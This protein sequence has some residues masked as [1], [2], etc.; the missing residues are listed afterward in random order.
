MNN[1]ALEVLA[2]DQADSFGEFFA[3][4]NF[5]MID[6][7]VAQYRQARERI[8]EVAAFSKGETCNSVISYFLDGNS[9]PDRGRH[10]LMMSAAQLFDESGAT[11]AL[12]AAYW[13]KALELTDVYNAMPQKRRDEWN[14]QLR[15]PK[16]VTKHRGSKGEWETPPLPDFEDETVRATLN[17]LLAARAQFL[18]ERVDGIF[19]ALSGE[20]VTNSPAAFGK[21]MIVAHLVSSYGTSN[22][23]R[24]GYI[25]DLR[26]VIAKFM[27]RDE[28]KWNMTSGI[29]DHA[30]RES[31]GQWV[32]VDGGA[33]RLRAYK[34]GTA[35]LEV[36][37]DMAWRLNS[38]L[39]H[40]YPMAIP[41]EFR[42]KPKKKA[43]EF[44]AMGRPLPFA[45]VELL[46][47]AKTAYRLIPQPDNWRQQYRRE[48]I[49]DTLDISHSGAWESAT[50]PV[51]D[52]AESVFRILGGVK[53]ANGYWQ[54]DYRPNEVLGE[55]VRTGC[56][57]DQKT[58]QFYP[59]PEGLAQIAVGLA[60][61]GDDHQCLEPSAGIGG[62]ADF[63]PI[64]RTTCI[65]VSR[66]HCEVLR[67]KGFTSVEADFP[68]WVDLQF[69][70]AAK[71]DRVVMNPPFSDGRAKA[72]TEFAAQCLKPGG[73]LVAIL[74]ASMKG[75]NF[76]SGFECEWSAIYDNEFAGTSVSV[77]ILTAKKQGGEP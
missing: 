3:P 19:R 8:T 55:A 69:P 41:P 18:A 53:S 51:R 50:K 7:L 56:I 23:D 45:V 1:D 30:R 76:L 40:L 47:E 4:S 64:E 9:D 2:V 46:S 61:I 22:H 14:A 29:V 27:G 67:A 33:L 62:L 13:S 72:H 15:Y 38:I 63:M 21:R 68:Y 6:V 42:S 37:P 31:R 58:H 59:T 77:V 66:L 12:N 16:G 75:K 39:A 20:H 54:F 49:K 74:P 52:E 5:D 25:N 43:K 11:S 36:H 35:H 65:E 28:P 60:E 70:N 26:C 32:S 48:D 73:R 71:F 17:G 44:A 24:V 10:S 57:P 34:C